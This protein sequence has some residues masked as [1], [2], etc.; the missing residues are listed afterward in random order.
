[1]GLLTSDERTK[2]V[3]SRPS[4]VQSALPVKIPTGYKVSSAIFAMVALASGYGVYHF[5]GPDAFLAPAGCVAFTVLSSAISAFCLVCGDDEKDHR[6]MMLTNPI[7]HEELMAYEGSWLTTYRTNNSDYWFVRTPNKTLHV[8]QD[9]YRFIK[10]RTGTITPNNTADWM[11]FYF[12]DFAHWRVSMNSE[13]GT[14]KNTLKWMENIIN[15]QA[16]S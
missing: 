15:N 11:R 14:A 2:V 8:S 9:V 10:E 1:M 7:T 12:K 5:W 4:E 6:R 13:Q 3:D 16:K